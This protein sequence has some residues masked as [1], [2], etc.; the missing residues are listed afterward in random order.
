MRKEPTPWERKLWQHLKSSQLQGY[1]FRRQQT[2]GAYIADFYNAD[3][4]LIVEL[5]GSQH[6]DSVADAARD[7]ALQALGYRILRIWNNDIDQN[8][9]GVL[10]AILGA[11]ENTPHRNAQKRFDS[12]SGG[13]WEQ[14]SPSSLPTHNAPAAT[15]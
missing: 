8:L 3:K 5:D 12:P 10:I 1:K 13:E 9:E 15:V 14:D 2:I 6:A 11:L 7:A 4:R